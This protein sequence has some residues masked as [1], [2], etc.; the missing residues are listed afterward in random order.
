MHT[1]H[2][3]HTSHRSYYDQ[4]QTKM[5]T[6]PGKGYSTQPNPQLQARVQETGQGLPVAAAW[7]N[8][9][10]PMTKPGAYRL[11]LHQCTVHEACGECAL[12]QTPACKSPKQPAHNKAVSL[13]GTQQQG[14]T[15]KQHNLPC[16]G[17]EDHKR[18]SAQHASPIRP[19]P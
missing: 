6:T 13:P 19:S 3:Q 11:L 15:V 8:H 1:A 12:V 7:R 2:T 10:Q 5:H 9:K 16:A 18:P 17:T 4:T 14:N